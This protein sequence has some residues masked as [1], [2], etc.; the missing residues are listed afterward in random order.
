MFLPGRIENYSPTDSQSEN[1][2]FIKDWSDAPYANPLA[3]RL[4]VSP[5][6][7]LCLQTKPFSLLS[8]C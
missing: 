3:M 5:T 2:F 6:N 7:D 4:K 8:G 1:E